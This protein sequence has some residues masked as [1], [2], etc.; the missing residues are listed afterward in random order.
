M[1]KLFN[2]LI[3]FIHPHPCIL[4]IFFIVATLMFSSDLISSVKDDIP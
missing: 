2:F 4:V 1:K 3:T